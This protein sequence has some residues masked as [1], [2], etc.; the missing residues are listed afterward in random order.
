MFFRLLSLTRTR[1]LLLPLVIILGWL[2]GLA[3]ILQAWT[4]SGVVDAVFL[5]EKTLTNVTSLLIVL[6]I[7]ILVRAVAQGTSGEVANL[8]A[9][10]VKSDLRSRLLAH[11]AKLGPAYSRGERTGELAAV[12]IEGIEALDLWFSQYLPQV[13][14]AAFIPISVLF[15]VFP[16][17]PLTGLVFLL[18]APLIPFFMVLIGKMAQ[19]LTIRQWETLSR[20]SAGMLD[21]L[22][23]LATLKALGQS[24]RQEEH[25]RESSDRFRDVTLSVLRIT[26]LSALALELLSTLSTAIVAVEIGLRLLYGRMAFHQAL[27]ILVLAPD[28][29]LPL[30]M[31]GQRFHAGMAGVAAAQRIFTILKTELSPSRQGLPHPSSHTGGQSAC[32]KFNLTFRHV[33]CS[34]PSR[35]LP[36]LQDLSFEL[37]HGKLTALIGPTGAGKSTVASLLLRF[38]EPTSGEILL[39]GIPLVNF[40][41]NAWR[42]HIAWVSQSPSLF[43]DTIAANLRLAKPYANWDEMFL[44]CQRAGLEDLITR[45]PQGLDTPIGERG[46]QLSGGQIQRIALARAFLRDAPLLIL[47]EP[48]SSLDPGLEAQLFTSVQELVHGRTVLVIAHRLNTVRHADSILV[49][50]AGRIVESGTHAS[51]LAAGGRYACMLQL[52]LEAGA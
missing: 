19:T 35:G 49:M 7:A 14:L 52:P 24:R 29:Y 45:L 4:L 38:I 40:P 12:A 22:Q 39:D 11:I 17:D 44:A 5:G 3:T 1:R 42:K 18:T 48:T 8:L 25:I 41:V 6:G 51:L 34:Y 10:H 50:E 26:F 37:P 30:R 2:A 15:F 31:L 16:L 36:A 46:A 13:A 32:L 9:L 43:S 21:M 33:S 20:L 27:F 23:G 28:F 47:D